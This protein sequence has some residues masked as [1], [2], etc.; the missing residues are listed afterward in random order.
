MELSILEGV[1]KFVNFTA[2]REEISS[3]KT[4]TH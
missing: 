4:L 2:D 1:L 3:L